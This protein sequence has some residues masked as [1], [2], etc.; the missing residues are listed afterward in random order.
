M[1]K[2]LLKKYQINKKGFTLVE[3][4]I[5]IAIIGIL[6]T[7][8]VIAINPLQLLN[9]ARDARRRSD[10]NQIRAGMQLFYNETKSY[11]TTATSIPFGA[12]WSSGGGCTGTIYMRQV[13]NDAA[14]SYVYSGT[15]TCGATCTEYRIT[16]DLN[17]QTAE[18]TSTITKCGATDT[19]TID[20]VV[21]ND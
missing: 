3:L 11:P 2:K 1:I 12:C 18:D 21:C 17:T 13:P 19:A 20:F 10:L 9:N 8:V 7:I 15:G 14:G 16:A 4:L 5:V 6:V